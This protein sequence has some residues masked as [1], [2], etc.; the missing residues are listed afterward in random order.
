M[1][2]EY[3]PYCNEYTDYSLEDISGGGRITCTHCGKRI[4]ACAACE[5]QCKETGRKVCFTNADW[6]ARILQN[7]VH[8]R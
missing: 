1:F 7:S 6:K 4:H 3:C 2:E 5:N 8:R